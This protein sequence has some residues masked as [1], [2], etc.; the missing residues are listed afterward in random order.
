MRIMLN[1]LKEELKEVEIKI[2]LLNDK[3]KRIKLIIKQNDN[4][5][6]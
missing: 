6:I 1:R 5:S 2:D 4:G 3:I